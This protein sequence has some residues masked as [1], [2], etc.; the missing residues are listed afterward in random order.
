[1]GDAVVELCVVRIRLGIGLSDA[2]G[3][4]FAVALLVASVL[5]V[6]ALHACGVLEKIATQGTAHDVV[7]LLL[8]K[9]VTILLDHVFFALSNGSLSAKT[10][11]KRPFRVAVF[12]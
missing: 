4:N 9:F 5:A 11:V 1:M 10:I 7:K 2:F 12:S 8:D 6:C 3:D